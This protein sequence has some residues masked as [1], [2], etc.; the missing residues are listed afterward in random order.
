MTR[1]NYMN[2]QLF[3]VEQKGNETKAPGR[4]VKS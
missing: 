3:E 1:A 2:K 4:K